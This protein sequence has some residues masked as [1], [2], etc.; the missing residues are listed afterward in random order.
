MT[1]Q[2]ASKPVLMADYLSKLWVRMIVR[3]GAAAESALRRMR[4]GDYGFNGYV[5]T[6]AE[7][8][9]GN[10]FDGVE[11]AETIVAG[12]GFKVA[13]NVVRSAPY[14]VGPPHD[15]QYW[16]KLTTPLTRGFGDELPERRVT[17][18]SMKGDEV[19]HCPTGLLATG[20]EHFCLVV[21]RTDLQSGS[22]AAK[23]EVTPVATELAVDGKKP[24]LDV[25]IEL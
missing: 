20:A 1:R 6:V 18:E 22:Y 16:V 15:C 5:Q 14:P 23:V 17:F 10:L 19:T 12:T 25:T 13:S 7:L 21:D 2:E 4:E 8:I 9:D 11:L 24:E 3:N